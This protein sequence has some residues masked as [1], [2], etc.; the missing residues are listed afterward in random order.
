[1]ALILPQN[2]PPAVDPAAARLEATLT[3]LPDDWTL[4]PDR[5]IGGADGPLAGFILVHP[6]IGVAVIDLAPAKPGR[7]LARLR[8]LLAAEHAIGERDVLPMVAVALTPDE[9]PA[10]GERLA[11]AFDAVPECDIADHAWPRRIIDLLLDADDAAMSPLPVPQDR[12]IERETISDYD[13][14]AP[15]AAD[16]P[17][18]LSAPARRHVTFAAACAAIIAVIGLGGAATYL[19]TEQPAET[20]I[21]T[22][23]SVP[24]PQ[25]V[26]PAPAPKT[27]QAPTIAP[28]APA[29]V[30]A[31]P[32]PVPPPAPQVAQAPASAPEPSARI[33]VEPR[34]LPQAPQDSSKFAAEG[35]PPAVADIAPPQAV[36]PIPAEPPPGAIKPP[37]R[38]AAPSPVAAAAKPHPL[39]AA[40]PPKVAPK[41][42]RK[43]VASA[44][45]QAPAQAKPAARRVASLEPRA[46]ANSEASSEAAAPRANASPDELPPL[47]ASDLPALEAQPGRRRR[48]TCPSEPP[49]RSPRPS[50]AERRRPACR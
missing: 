35:P 14:E 32:H 11:E 20:P 7:A 31:E 10:V 49:C 12:A 3:S 8:D 40:P 16:E 50:P 23:L 18:L 44:A 47:D 25:P 24:L 43:E 30:V 46:K 17:A 28:E 13:Y 26:P 2:L 1:M 42:V 34:P 39:K 33:T 9:I 27:A 6:E 36:P 15:L 4:L 19:L 37:P 21:A 48:R 5:Q 41:P 22:A 45:N 29:P 38:A